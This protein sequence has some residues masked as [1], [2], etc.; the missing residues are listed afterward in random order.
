VNSADIRKNLRRSDHTRHDTR[1]IH[2]LARALAHERLH[3]NTRPPRRGASSDLLWDPDG[4]GYKVIARTVVSHGE[5]T[6]FDVAVSTD[7]DYVLAV[8]L[9][10]STFTLLEMVRIPWPTVLW[11][12]TAGHTRV[13]CSKLRNASDRVRVRASHSRVW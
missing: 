13:L 2:D 1:H 4:S 9:S 3:L 6:T 7:A 11:L 12:G 10:R 8:F 5:S